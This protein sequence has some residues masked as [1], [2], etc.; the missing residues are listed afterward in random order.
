[1]QPD[2]I[3]VTGDGLPFL[4]KSTLKADQNACAALAEMNTDPAFAS[5]IPYTAIEINSTDGFILPGGHAKGGVRPYLESTE[6][7]AKIAEF[8]DA[9]KVVGAVCH[10]VVV[11]GRS[12][13][14]RTGLGSSLLRNY[15]LFSI[16]FP[17]LLCIDQH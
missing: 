10:G 16:F 14:S 3:M 4:F 6:L 7:Q 11:V 8:F 17:S 5:P 15:F 13:S 2:P 9:D 12:V 1:M